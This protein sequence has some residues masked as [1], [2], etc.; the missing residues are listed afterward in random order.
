MVKQL[1][2][3]GE[4]SKYVEKILIELTN[5][6][7]REHKYSRTRSIDDLKREIGLGHN[8]IKDFFIR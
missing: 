8:E 4:Q 6:V 3:F 5:V 7:G 1:E 2:S